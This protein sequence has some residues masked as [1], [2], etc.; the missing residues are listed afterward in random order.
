MRSMIIIKSPRRGFETAFFGAQV[1]APWPKDY[2]P[3]RMIPEKTRHIT[4][5]FLGQN[6]LS[7]V[8]SFLSLRLPFLFSSWAGG[9]CRRIGLSPS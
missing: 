4:L 1:E 3:A 9:H 8:Q 2:P 7:H 6:P 5:A